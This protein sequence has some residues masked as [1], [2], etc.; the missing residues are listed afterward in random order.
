LESIIAVL[1]NPLTVSVVMVV[2]GLVVKFVPALERVPNNLI[3]LQNTI[4]GILARIAAPEDA[5]AAGFLGAVGKGLV[6]TF[7]PMLPIVQAMF[8]RQVFETFIR[9]TLDLKRGIPGEP[10]H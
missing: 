5:E 9:P 4:I 7:G 1:T 2:W 3:W 10:P 6:A 8:A